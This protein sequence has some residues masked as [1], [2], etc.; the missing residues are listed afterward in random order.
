MSELSVLTAAEQVAAHLREEL[1]RGRWKDLMPGGDRLVK[2]L[3]VGRDTIKEALK[4]LER[5]GFLESQG[6]RRQRRIVMTPTPERTKPLR[7]KIL[8]YEDADRHAQCDL[9]ILAELQNKGYAANFAR[10]SLRELGMEVGRV[11]NFVAKTPADAWILEAGSREI[12]EWFSLYH[13]P[14]MALFGSF[15]GLSLAGVGLRKTPAMR[16]ALRRLVD[17]GHRRIVLLTRE[18]R[19]KPQPALLERNYLLELAALGVKSGSYNLPDWEESPQGLQRCLDG[20]FAYTPPTAILIEDLQL[21]IPVEQ[22]LARRKIVV[23][24]QVSLIV[25]DSHPLFDW[26]KP[27]IAQVSGDYQKVVKRV[28]RWVESVAKGKEDHR[29]TFVE[30]EFIEGGTIGPVVVSR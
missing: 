11:S 14:A 5:E 12:M 27:M 20:L 9:R 3:G 24:G 8:H 28:C 22:Y 4:Q 26:S 19:H 10:R 30:A 18:E 15:T 25:N 13:V 6:R 1:R 2:E 21:F 16:S 23:P 29:Q 7:V 17:L